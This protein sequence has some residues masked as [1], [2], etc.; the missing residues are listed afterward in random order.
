MGVLVQQ[1]VEGGGL[2]GV[3]GEDGGGLVI[4]PVHGGTAAADVIVVHTGQVVMDQAVGVDAFEG[5]GGAQHRPLLDVEQI[6]RLKREEGP[7]PLAGAEGGIAHG[8]GQARFGAVGA[9][10][11]LVEGDR[12][13]I[14]DLG[15]PVD[16]ALLRRIGGE[17]SGGGDG[18]QNSL[19]PT[20][21][22]RSTPIRTTSPAASGKPRVRTSDMKGPIWRGGKLT[23]AAT[24]RPSSWSRV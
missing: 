1:D 18:G 20:G 16:D 8:F 10:Q 21:T 22:S 15:H 24:L 2:E 13:Q 3:A 19:P 5:A 4:G 14:G 9:G 7:Q 23:T 12:D 11:Q 17:D 6:G